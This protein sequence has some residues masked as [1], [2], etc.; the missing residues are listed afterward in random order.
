[1]KAELFSPSL[2]VPRR[3]RNECRSVL[4]PE[5]KPSTSSSATKMLPV[6]MLSTRTSSR[7]PTAVSAAGTSS[8]AC[9]RTASSSSAR[10]STTTFANIIIAQLLF[11]E[12]EDPDKDIMLY[13]NCPGGVVTAGLAIYD[14]MQYVRCPVVD[15][16]HGAGGVDGRRPACARAR[17]GSRYALP[18]TPHH[19]PPAAGR[20][21]G[22]G[23]GHR[24]PRPRDPATSRT[25][26]RDSSQRTPASRS[27]GSRR[28]PSATST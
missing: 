26:S 3:R 22:S 15:H 23:D 20:L 24:D 18:N 17:K 13:I 5:P 6:T 4:K 10:R 28:T 1:M 8:A 21:R 7:R 19:D 14:T 9:S 11:L 12:S 2:P 16:L 27:S 25:C